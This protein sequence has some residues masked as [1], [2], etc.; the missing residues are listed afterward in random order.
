MEDLSKL[1][2]IIYDDLRGPAVD[3]RDNLRD[4]TEFK[5][6]GRYRFD[7]IHTQHVT[8]SLRQAVRDGYEWAVVVAVGTWLRNSQTEVL[9]TLAH[10][11]EENAPLACHILDQGGYFH[12][13]PQWFA[14]DLRVYDQLGQP[15]LEEAPGSVTVTTR[16]TVRCADNAHDDYTPWWVRPGEDRE[17]EYTS[18]YRYFGIDL[19]AD[20]IRAGYNITNIP[21]K[22]REC[23][24]YCYPN[25]QHETLKQMIADPTFVPERTGPTEALWWFDRSLKELVKNLN[26]GYYVINT[27]GVTPAPQMQGRTFDCFIGVCGGQKP[28]VIVGMPEFQEHTRVVLYDIS[29]AALQ[30]QQHLLENWDGDFNDFESVYQAFD[31]QHPDYVPIYFRDKSIAENVQWFYQSYG[32][33]HDEFYQRWQKYRACEFE[34]VHLDLHAAD[35]GQRIGTMAQ[36]AQRSTYVWTS[37]AFYMDYQMFYWSKAGMHNMFLNFIQDIRSVNKSDI[38]VENCNGIL[39]L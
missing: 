22:I 15:A 19:V 34:F 35:A 10:A 32:I 13:H 5:L 4:F 33:D 24:S 28:A 17:V 8:E 16:H 39:V 18:D 36:R 3:I 21:Q 23:K 20:L 9:D 37:N 11:R 25:H 29:P 12:F 6:Q 26:T 38:I 31:A 30:F 2:V 14:L 7:L 27:E 1:A